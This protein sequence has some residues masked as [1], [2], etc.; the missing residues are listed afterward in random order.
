LT[1]FP[2][3]GLIAL[4]NRKENKRPAMKTKAINSN[5]LGIILRSARKS[6]GL[7]QTEA[8]KL[9]GVDQTTISKVERGE[10]KVRI[11]TLFRILAALDLEIIIQPK[12]MWSD[13]NEGD[14][15]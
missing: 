12:K 15:W 8:G 11:D 4:K 13:L 9:L 3:Y 1:I 6:K 7:N 2:F 10:S 14:N 5:S